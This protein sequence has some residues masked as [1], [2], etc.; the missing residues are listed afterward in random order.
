MAAV[1]KKKSWFVTACSNILS[2]RFSSFDV[3]PCLLLAEM[4]QARRQGVGDVR[5]WLYV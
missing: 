4:D 5:K 1:K 3:C 2:V